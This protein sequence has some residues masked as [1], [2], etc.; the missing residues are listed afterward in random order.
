MHST[1]HR[2]IL[3]SCAALLCTA[4]PIEREDTAVFLRHPQEQFCSA[5]FAV[6]AE[7]LPK[8]QSREENHKQSIFEHDLKIYHIYK[9]QEKFPEITINITADN[10]S[11]VKAY[12]V[13]VELR[14]S[15]EY[16]LAGSIKKGEILLNQR[17][18]IQPWKEV[19]SEQR[20]GIERFYGRNCECHITPA[21]FGA[22]DCV[23]PLKGCQV[24]HDYHTMQQFYQGCEWRYSYCKKNREATACSWQETAE[25]RNCRDK[26]LP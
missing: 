21:C 24:S 9:G 20:E 23:Q 26:V 17:S 1:I 7:V 18:W 8:N 11:F 22:T 12:S 5:D 10:G 16:F 25:Y 13:H 19:T 15:T 14:S 2:V 3:F 4:G 6:R